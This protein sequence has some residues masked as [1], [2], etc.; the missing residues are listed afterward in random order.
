MKSTMRQREFPKTSTTIARTFAALLLAPLAALHAAEPAADPV[1]VTAI[2]GEYDDA[3][4]KKA[5]S[6]AAITVAAGGLPIILTAPHG[7]R[8]A[9]PGVPERKG[10]AASRFNPRPDSNTD[11]LV[12][13]LADAL[14][15]KLGKRPYVVIARFHRKY[16]DAN[17]RPQDAFESAEAKAIYE[18]YHAAIASACRE[19]TSRWGRGIVLDIHGQASQ[20][21]V[22]LR[23]TQNGK[24]VAHLLKQSGREAVF[25]E[26]SLFGQLAKQ[27]FV[28]F[29]PVGSSDPES[30]NYSGGHTVGTHGSSSGGT[31]DAIQLELGTKHRDSKTIEDV[32]DKLANAI[33]AFARSC[34]P[35]EEQKPVTSDA[36]KRTGKIA[37]GVY[38]DKGAGPSVNDLLRA[39]S[40][41]D[42]VSVTKLTAEQIRSGGLA[43]LDIL[44][45]PGGS[46]GEQGRNLDEPGR[47]KIRDFVREGGG[48][49]G[50]CAGAYLATA[51]YPWS[52]NI[53]DA[54]VIDT[55]HWNRGIG[56]VDIELTPAGREILRTKN[57]KLPIHY[58][59]G[60]LLAPANRPEIEDYEEMASF[61]TEIAKHGAPTGV[62]IGTTAIARGRFGQGRVICFSPHP[63]M[64]EGLEAFVQ[65]AID[66]VNRKPAGQ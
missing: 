64:T 10:D 50:I 43:G 39:L 8:A 58:A 65:D 26:T 62:M 42:Q 63:E 59:Q 4:N 38:L 30:P 31:I 5:S 23:G 45:H 40:K 15:Q 56:T 1:P 18:A 2:S 54:R 24:T 47:K 66:Y 22:V 16:I 14:E 7:G 57:Q 28:V 36:S 46:G 17:R 11:I 55:K 34:L 32:A 37:V 9:I 61:K 20:P 13:K 25:G 51:Q 35:A 12:E 27:G 49:I 48:Y 53:L 41:F 3:S 52:L 29:P 60:P 44:M 21:D 33:T 6:N 19:V